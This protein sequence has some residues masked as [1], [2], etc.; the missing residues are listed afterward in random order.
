M[1]CKICA[2]HSNLCAKNRIV[3]KNF[4]RYLSIPATTMVAF[5]AP[6][7]LP[8]RATNREV[9]QR[10]CTVPRRC[11]RPLSHVHHQTPLS[12]SAASSTNE[13]NGEAESS[14]APPVPMPTLYSAWFPPGNQIAEQL[15]V[16]IA[17]SLAD[18]R[19]RME[20]NF[21]CVQIGG[22]KVRDQK[23]F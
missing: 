11:A 20:I 13:G 22:D 23:Q 8:I 4:R 10:A 15:S 14:G 16:A 3:E 6:V 17:A 19:P 9:A 1:R 7:T 12:A 5:A 18:G 21:P 2:S